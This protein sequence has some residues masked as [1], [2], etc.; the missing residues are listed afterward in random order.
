LL[1]YHRSLI[2]CVKE[3]FN[4]VRIHQQFYK[5]DHHSSEEGGCESDDDDDDSYDDE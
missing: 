3:N 5:F 2:N 1:S 4:S